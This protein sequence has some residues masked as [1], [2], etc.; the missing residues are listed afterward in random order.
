MV[1][2]HED[3]RVSAELV[4][5]GTDA[6]PLEAVMEPV[7]EDEGPPLEPQQALAEPETDEAIRAEGTEAEEVVPAETLYDV[8]GVTPQA[9]RDQIEKA[10]RFCLDMYKEGALATYSLL[11]AGD[12]EA[13]RRKISFAHETL[14]DTERRRQYDL[15]LGLVPATQTV[16]PFS[17]RGPGEA[18]APSAPSV[19]VP[20]GP[21]GGADLRRVRESR[22]I[23]LREVAAST[24]IGLRFLEY[25]E[26]DRFEMLPPAVYLRGFLQEY[27]RVLG[28]DPRR[29]T[30]AYMAR[31]P[32]RV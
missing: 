10:H 12:A 29:T 20:D 4:A 15:S 3:A 19:A 28:M 6:S 22:G 2:P 16:V 23:A 21:I 11:D 8:L 18:A 7:P 26:D 9:S 24:K 31:M 32:G 14:A 13:A 1:D 17:V 30:E 27:A 25:L 5:R